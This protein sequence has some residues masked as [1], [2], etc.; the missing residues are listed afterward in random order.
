MNSQQLTWEI[1]LV[2]CPMPDSRSSFAQIDHTE[3]FTPDTPICLTVN[4][5]ET[6]PEE[7]WERL[8]DN[9]LDYQ[10]NC[11]DESSSCVTLYN[12]EEAD[13]FLRSLSPGDGMEEPS[14]VE[15]IAALMGNDQTR[16]YFGSGDL[17]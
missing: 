15:R 1:G 13:A 17:P 9:V 16:R 14:L 6:P 5:V 12:R 7:V 4:G 8:I 3:I 11:T 2:T 10:E